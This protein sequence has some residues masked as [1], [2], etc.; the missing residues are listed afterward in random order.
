[1]STELTPEQ[2][3]NLAIAELTGMNAAHPQ[4]LAITRNI[5]DVLT[6]PDGQTHIDGK[7]YEVLDVYELD[8]Y[9]PQPGTTIW[10]RCLVLVEDT[11]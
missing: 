7:V 4:V 3:V 8:A 6:L 9:E 2:K 11:P 10:N 1:M 5:V